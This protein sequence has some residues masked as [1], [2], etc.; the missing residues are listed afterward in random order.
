VART[1]L[2]PGE[3]GPLTKDAK[4]VLRDELRGQM[5]AQL[6]EKK[7]AAEKYSSGGAGAAGAGEVRPS[8]T[9]PW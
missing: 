2:P 1:S 8:K 3:A 5:E 6:H 7:V 9:R 4:A